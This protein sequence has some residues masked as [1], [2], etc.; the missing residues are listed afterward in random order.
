MD[1]NSRQLAEDYFLRV[2]ADARI[3]FKELDKMMLI[4]NYIVEF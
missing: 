3:R 2:P 4:S 1:Y